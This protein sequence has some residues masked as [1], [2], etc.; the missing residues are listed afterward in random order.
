MKLS[1]R[2]RLTLWNT[3]GWAVMVLA[4]AA[5]V[6]GML[7]HTLYEQIDSRLLN[8]LG[9]MEQDGRMLTEPNKRLHHWICEWHEH[10]KLSAVAYDPDGNVWERTEQLA[11]DSVPPAPS[12]PRGEHRLQ[13]W[14]IPILGRQRVLESSLALGHRPSTIVVMAPLEGV[15]HEL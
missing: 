3:L 6:Y 8:A 7:R 1:I 13:D 4:F 15:D 12:I 11:A 10:E 14:A 5:L 2:W 9:Q